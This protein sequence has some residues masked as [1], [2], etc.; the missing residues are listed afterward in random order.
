MKL[1]YL[2]QYTQ[3]TCNSTVIRM[4]ESQLKLRIPSQTEHLSDE[5]L[6]KIKVTKI[7]TELPMSSFV[8]IL[9]NLKHKTS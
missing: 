7:I 6:P 5:I 2:T 4:S 3:D 9:P 1:S 8:Q